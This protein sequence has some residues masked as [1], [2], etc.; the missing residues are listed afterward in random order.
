ME[1]LRKK[2]SYHNYTLS[3]PHQLTISPAIALFFC[4]SIFIIVH[5][6]KN[7]TDII[8]RTPITLLISF[9][10]YQHTRHSNLNKQPRRAVKQHSGPKL[11]RHVSKHIW[12]IHL[13][14]CSAHPIQPKAA[15]VSQLYLCNKPC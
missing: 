9:Q 10:F 11:E 6:K 12:L 14:A 4:R 3:K 7:R 15:I 5:T 8:Q 13:T 2:L 1:K